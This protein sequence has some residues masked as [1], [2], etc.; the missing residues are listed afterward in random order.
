[1]ATHAS[2]RLLIPIS[3]RDH[4]QGPE[5]APV[6]L[7]EYGDYECPHCRQVVPI[8]HELR[9]RF[10]DRL[11]YVFR[12]FPLSTAHPDA[13]LAAEAAEAAG[14]QGKFWEMHDLLFEHQGQLDTRHLI[15]Y[16]A[17][18][19]LDLAR[20]EQ[21]VIGRV[22]ASHV[23]EDFAGGVRSG[24]NGTP[25]FYLNGVRYD[26]PWD[27]DSLV[28]EVEKPL[29]VQLRLL[30]QQFTRLQ[31]SSGILLLAVTVLALVWANSPWGDTYFELWETHLTFALGSMS[32]S[33][34]LVHW[35]NDG[36][37]VIFF[38]VVGLEIK[39]EILVGELASFRRAALPLIAAVGGMVLPAAIYV[40]FNLG[41]ESQSG[42]GMPMATD[43]AFVL[44]ILAVLG[45][46]VPVS[47]KVFF[48]ALAIADDLGAVLV[49]ALFY[50]GEILWTAL[51][52]A[53]IFLLALIILNRLGVRNPL[54]Y[55]LLGVG[56]W[57]AFLE[58]GVHP[59]IAGVLLA[60]T[61]PARTTVR[62]EA[63]QA[64]CISALSGFEPGEGHVDESRRQ[65]AAAQT[66]EVIAERLQSPLQRL[67]RSLNP[68]VAY[69]VVPVF[70]LANAGV[71]LEGDLLEVL[72]EPV[73][74]GIIGGL[75]LGKSLGITLFS[76][77]AVKTGAA[78]LPFGVSWVHLF[79]ASWLAG[80]GFTMS[81]FIASSAFDSVLLLGMAKL[82]ILVA[83]T[84]AAVIGFVLVMWTS[85]ARE[86]ASKL[87][88]SAAAPQA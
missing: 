38:F 65:Q 51:G 53:A 58:S 41:R 88:V 33:E 73:S 39:R 44:A 14:A 60:M 17:E 1:M 32:L 36:L 15:Q 59:T 7:V 23:R 81:L 80:I 54:P 48:T 8:I 26:G 63:Y 49:L 40:A 21:E 30:F 10:G 12:H 84:L 72:A 42:W 45:N 20:F 43:I 68:Y 4:V 50:S 74:L 62:A 35:V 11:R 28:A 9:A 16:A 25:T 22:H 57:L 69:V 87:E 52:V 75:V 64:Q 19:G 56:L 24:A 71:R 78:E 86:G 83:S 66:L 34:S 5:N 76:W 31:A 18:L 67:E 37:M 46:R 77:I 79:S 3:E 82:A 85:P 2:P 47:L 27:L 55:S 13:Q 61:I 29:G 70:A 6:T